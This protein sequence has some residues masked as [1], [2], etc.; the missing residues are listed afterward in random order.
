MTDP[1][2]A[3]LTEMRDSFDHSFAVAHTAE[4]EAGEHFLAI[5]IGDDPLAIR[6]HAIQAIAHVTRIVALPS[7][8]PELLGLAGLRGDLIPLYDLGALLQYP[9]L[10]RAPRWFVQVGAEATL[11]L[12]FERLDGYQ[13][14]ATADRLET[15][16][17]ATTRVHTAGLVRLQD[18]MRPVIDLESLVNSLQNRLQAVRNGKE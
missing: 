9:P 11:G 15:A 1:L 17:G 2:V 4:A 12:A 13:V 16:T 18:E 7:P 6:V 14:A 5:R 3:R 10:S 8:M